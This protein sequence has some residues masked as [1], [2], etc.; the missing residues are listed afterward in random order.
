[1]AHRLLALYELLLRPL[2]GER[3][4][5][6][7]APSNLRLKLPPESPDIMENDLA[8]FAVEVVTDISGVVFGNT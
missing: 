4:P 8:L 2:P 6:P 5:H 3:A 7:G 1:M